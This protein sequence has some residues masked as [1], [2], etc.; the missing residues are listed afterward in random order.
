MR[1]EWR[2]GVMGILYRG[3]GV[4]GGGRMRHEHRGKP[5]VSGGHRVRVGAARG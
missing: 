5:V 4:L 3:S 1:G 2:E